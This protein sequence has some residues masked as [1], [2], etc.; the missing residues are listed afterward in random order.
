MKKT[1]KKIISS[2]LVI[3][4]FVLVGCY[5]VFA[6]DVCPDHPHQSIYTCPRHIDNAY[7]HE[8][9]C[10]VCDLMFGVEDCTFSVDYDCTVRPHCIMCEQLNMDAE[11]HFM[12]D[13]SGSWSFHNNP[14]YP[15]HFQD[16]H[17]AG[18]LQT[19]FERHTYINTTIN[20]V[21]Y[22]VCIGCGFNRVK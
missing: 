16:C 15:Y 10:S 12:H 2:V 4:L 11:V 20:G 3:A 1:V 9:Y 14:S 22:E 19:A 18:C 8:Y 5:S 17:N 6:W 21:V 13:Y 7:Y